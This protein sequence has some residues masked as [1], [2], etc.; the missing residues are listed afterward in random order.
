MGNIA[1]DGCA[2]RCNDYSAPEIHPGM[3]ARSVAK[4]GLGGLSHPTAGAPDA[5]SA[6]P[7]DPTVP[8]KRKRLTD[9]QIHPSMSKPGFDDYSHRDTAHRVLSDAV[10]S[11]SSKLPPV[12]PIGRCDK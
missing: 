6:N 3:S 10:L 5:S 1:R 11:G 7:L 8:G 2:K 4:A 9:L 12:A